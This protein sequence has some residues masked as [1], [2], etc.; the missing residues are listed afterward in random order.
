[1]STLRQEQHADPDILHCLHFRQHAK[2]PSELPPNEVHRLKAFNNCLFAD[3]QDTLWL[4]C[5]PD[6]ALYVPA[7]LR[8]AILCQLIRANPGSK[9]PR[10]LSDKLIKASYAWPKCRE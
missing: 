5:G 2:W 8:P 9:D 3:H 7:P 6:T 10:F 4:R 1:M